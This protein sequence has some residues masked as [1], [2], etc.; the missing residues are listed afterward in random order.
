MPRAMRSASCFVTGEVVAQA[1]SPGVHQR[2]AELLLVG[3]LAD[4]HLHQRRPAEEDAGAVLDHDRVVAHARE[5]GATRGRGAEDHADGRDALRRELGQ[6]AE[7]LAAGHE[8]VGLAGQVRPSGLD[9]DQNRE[10]VLLGHVHGAQELADRGRARGAAAHRRVVRDD[11]ALRMRHLGQRDHDAAADRVAGVE[12]GQRAELEHGRAGVD[13]RLEALAHHHLAA[14]PVPFDV[15]RAAARQHL[16][17]QRAHLVDEAAHGVRLGAVLGVR[18]AQQGAQRRAHRCVVLT[19]SCPTTAGASP[20][21][22]PCPRPPRHRRRARPT[23]RRAVV[24]PSAQ[25]R[26]GR[27][28]SRPFVARSAPGAAWRIAVVSFGHPLVERRLA[29]G[30]DGAE[31]A[32]GHGLVRAEAFAGEG[33]A[34]EKASV[35]DAE[36]RHQDHRRRHADA[37]LGEGE[38]ARLGR[39]RHVG[40]GDEP[41]AAGPC[42]A[43]DPGDHR[44]RGSPRSS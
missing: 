35:H 19:P 6:A 25:S 28:R 27:S 3:V 34:G 44:H 16:V 31:E 30:R 13:E 23:G 5:V 7:L 1:R 22:P 8:D 29:V 24:R 36:G 11:E 2:A 33:H 39:D 41:E 20:G 37:D 14:G 18:R 42:M 12:P 15:L 21:T 43:V 10:A 17:V 40:G 9:E 26:C 4:R 32:G 38:R